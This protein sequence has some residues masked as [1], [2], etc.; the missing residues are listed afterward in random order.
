MGERW[1]ARREQIFSVGARLFAQKGYE[2][3]SLQEVADLLGVTKPALYY[4]FG[5]KAG[6]FQAVMEAAHDERYNLIQAAAKRGSSVP[7]RAW[8]ALSAQ[9]A[10]LALGPK[11]PGAIS[12]EPT[13]SRLFEAVIERGC[14]WHVRSSAHMAQFR[15]VQPVNNARLGAVSS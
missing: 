10:M 4:Y 3:T 1:D 6:I 14:A 11:P 9:W 5:D 12:T 13:H 15:L 2:R 7:Q 8:C